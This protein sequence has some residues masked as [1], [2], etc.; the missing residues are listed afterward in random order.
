MNCLFSHCCYI[1]LENKLYFFYYFVY[2]YYNLYFYLC[3]MSLTLFN[4]IGETWE[5]PAIDPEILKSLTTHKVLWFYGNNLL[6]SPYSPLL[7]TIVNDFEVFLQTRK[8]VLDNNDMNEAYKQIYYF[9]Q[10]Q[11]NVANHLNHFRARVNQYKFVYEVYTELIKQ[12]I[13]ADCSKKI[14]ELYKQKEKEMLD[15]E[16]TYTEKATSTSEN[17]FIT[18]KI[19]N[20]TEK[21][22]TLISQYT[23]TRLNNL[24]NSQ[25]KVNLILNEIR[26]KT[27]I[28]ETVVWYFELRFKNFQEE[29]MSWKKIIDNLSFLYKH[30]G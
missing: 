14:T 29:I 24:I 30:A 22:D 12:Q 17:K 1:L 27:Q 11:S 4:I 3:Y 20:I 8:W 23:G 13:D 9:T 18:I 19:N 2:T 25:L 5:N 26:R 7:D 6:S 28:L 10:I 21:Y 15:L 16:K